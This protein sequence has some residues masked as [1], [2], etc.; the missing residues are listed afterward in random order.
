MTYRYSDNCGLNAVDHYSDW[1]SRYNPANDLRYHNITGSGIITTCSAY[2]APYPRWIFK[3]KSMSSGI[4]ELADEC[5]NRESIDMMS[6]SS[7]LVRIG[8]KC[9]QK[10]NIATITLP[11]SLESIGHNNFPKTLKSINIPS[12]IQDFPVDNLILCDAL[13]I[14]SVS[15]GNEW[16]RIL[17]GNLY[18]NDLTE[19][20]YCPNAKSG[21]VLIP[22][23]VKKIGA[24]CFYGCKKITAILIPPS[25]EEIGNYAFANISMDTLIIP[26]SVKKI[27]V[28]CFTGMDIKKQFRLSKQ[29]RLIPSNCFRKAEYPK[30]DFFCKLFEIGDN[31]FDVTG[32]SKSLPET[33]SLPNVQ[34]IGKEA[35]KEQQ[36]TKVFELFSSLKCIE[37]G[38]FANTTENLSIRIHSFVPCKINKNAFINMSDNAILYVP[39]N[40]KII[41]EN[42]IPWSSFSRIEEVELY[43]DTKDNELCNVSDEVYLTRLKSITK[44]IK[45]VNREYVK[46]LIE[47]IAYNYQDIDNDED[48][49]N[50]LNLLAFNRIFSPAIIPDLERTL[51]ACWSNWYKLK[52]VNKAIIDAPASPILLDNNISEK[53][54]DYTIDFVKLPIRQAES[55]VNLPYQQSSKS[56]SIE[57]H[58]NDILKHIQNELS[59]ARSSIKVA[60]SWFTNYALFKQIKELSEKGIKIQIITNNDLINNGGYCLDFNK[61]IEANVEISLVE[62]PHLLHDKFC[63]IDDIAVI[64]G[65]YNWTR[66]SRNNYENISIFRNNPYLIQQFIDE[67]EY[68]WNKAEYKCIERMPDTV[69]VRPEYDRNA[70]RQY[71]TEELDAEARETL[72]E[73]DKITALQKASELNP[74]YFEKLNP[75]AKDS[76]GEAFNVIQQS[77]VI[78]KDIVSIVEGEPI[79]SLTRGDNGLSGCDT[80]TSHE[81]AKT[82][83]FSQTK[84]SIPSIQVSPI[85]TKEDIAKV[86]MVKASDLFMVLDVSGSM[87]DSYNAGHVYNITKKAVSAALAISASKEL[88]LWKFGDTSS[89]VKTIGVANIADI[90][91]VKCMSTGTNLNSFVT[92]AND[93]IKDDSLIIVFTDDDGGSI[94]DAVNGM[95]SRSNVFWQIIVYGKHKEIMTT[96]NGIP[97]ISLVSMSDY[98][99]KNDSDINHS[100]L[101]AYIEWKKQQ[102]VNR[103]N[104]N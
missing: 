26:N 11:E 12:K 95:K 81:S 72:D 15:E 66:F 98:T 21:K 43:Q 41:F 36:Q 62:Y 60:V 89:F 70:F 102:K 64:N 87:R 68:I 5:F 20:I 90:N 63:I 33:V 67:F 79:S 44:S 80:S 83:D 71:I 82:T 10:T 1:N 27:G 47:E 28:G 96:I 100:L 93:T 35:F 65:S 75:K 101:N 74:K 32:V 88:S 14:I 104:S 69:A 25:V 9:F 99:A 37:E 77:N 7:C 42:T 2:Q 57:V 61:L 13:E 4:T 29:I 39:K 31:A 76:F 30:N 85:V 58:F 18:N 55:L 56:S 92:K 51:C 48:Y 91:N 94:R 97:N 23:T 86:E 84:K 73:R 40:T 50:A 103:T 59:I 16:Y 45:E 52:I 49:E 22:D 24:Y 17:D 46:S 38:A 53:T 78:T 3:Y 8:N 19:I 6:L 54:S 34:Y